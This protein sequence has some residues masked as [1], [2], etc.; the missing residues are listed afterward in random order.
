MTDL[1]PCPTFDKF[2]RATHHGNEPFPWQTRLAGLV[3]GQGWPSEIGI[4]TGLGKTACLDIAVWALA[5]QAH[6]P[7]TERTA[8]TRVWYVVNRRLLVDT[9]A[10]HAETLA[11]WLTDPASLPDTHPEATSADIDAVGAVAA[12]LR[13]VGALG[14]E[15]GPLHVTRLR[16]GAD[17][18][19]RVPD[20]SQ[21]AV[22]L[23]TVPMFA[24]RWFFRGYGT[25]T[26][27]RP[28]DA[29]LAGTDS[30]VLLDEAHLAQ[31]LAGLTGPAAQCDVGDPTLVVPAGRA[32]PTVV[33][34]TATGQRSPSR[35][36]LDAAD[37]ADP[38]VDRRVNATKPTRLS[39]SNDKNLARDLASATID[40]LTAASAP[41]SCVVFTNSPGR[42]RDTH[43]LIET[44]V[45]EAG[46]AAD[47][48][49]ITGRMREHEADTVRS[50]LLDPA[51]GVRSGAPSA[52]S[53]HL[54]V[55]ATQTLE[56]GADVD[57]DH[58]VTESAGVRALVQ[59]FG[60]LNRLG[61]KPDATAVICHPAETNPHSIYGGEPDE[62]W[63]RL[64]AAAA[65]GPL[66]LGPTAITQVL[67][68]PSD[69]PPR[70][71]E[72]LP[73]HLWEWAKTTVPP[74]GEAPIEPFIES[75]DDQSATVTVVWRAW[76][77][78]T[79][80]DTGSRGALEP[81]LRGEEAVDVPISEARD[82][83][84]PHATI[85]RLA[86]D[87]TTIEPVAP[88]SIRPGDQLVVA[89]SSGGYDQ[90]G[91]DPHATSPVLD[92]SPLAAGV[93]VL[94]PAALANLVDLDT[95]PAVTAALHTLGSTL[96]DD[97]PADDEIKA[98]A[99]AVLAALADATPHPW[100]TEP[101]WSAFLHTMNNATPAVP[102]DGPPR[103]VAP[104]RPGQRATVRSD[105]SDELSL[106][107]SQLLDDHLTTVAAAAA[108]IGQH[109]G[110]NPDLIEAVRLA[111]AF[112]DQGKTDTRFQRWLDPTGRADNPVAKSTMTRD[113]WE[114]ARM[115]SGWP[116]GGRHET[117]SARLVTA[118]I[119]HGLNAGP[120][121]DLLIHLV[122]THHGHGRPSLP[123]VDDPAPTA[124]TATVA[125]IAVTV[126]GDLSA[127]EWDQPARFRRLCER[128]GYWG[129]AL[130]EAIVRQAD[131][132]A[133]AQ[134]NQT[135]TSTVEVA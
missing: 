131:H 54:V 13:S 82:W 73:S 134:T 128:Y 25:S 98:A 72:L 35:F 66:D 90:H 26:S 36:D 34:V 103:L 46:L 9:A 2:Y 123:T 117:L 16:G 88:A 105:A 61:T 28:I 125:G 7:P 53:T 91:W 121:P 17:L 85:C 14:S 8:P 106:A 120:D 50:F 113:Q 76:L 119:A 45:A 114:Q 81:R 100:I 64:T 87:R 115:A 129:L 44:G 111:G 102:V 109:I 15:R 107:Q 11:G 42:A 67:G 69:T 127:G 135:G 6:L 63:D 130:L 20:P 58:L 56:V 30:V 124:T 70:T 92:V 65:Q 18:G 104:R 78:D 84:A 31:P 39:E 55:V 12:R 116:R 60:R 29:A 4:P 49:L 57:F 86:P 89:A 3:A 33:T 68:E 43:R 52:R 112:H 21:P 122:A 71:A 19:A 74:P 83:L 37:F 110:L 38:V 1:P 47:V 59:R 79:D 80:T 101:E 51:T 95:A 24:S 132:A 75:L 94:E 96:N 108:L 77:P 5:A 99:A 10:D 22:V 23:A 62:V 97:D 93:L 48:V 27:M 126:S 32:R 40:L 133:S 118:A 41:S